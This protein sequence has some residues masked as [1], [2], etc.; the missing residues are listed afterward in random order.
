MANAHTETPVTASIL[1]VFQ[2]VKSG[3][4][5]KDGILAYSIV[6][7]GAGAIQVRES[8]H[9]DF[10]ADEWIKLASGRSITFEVQADELNRNTQILRI[11]ARRFGSVSSTISGG[12]VK[13]R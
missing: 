7:D 11:Q 4:V 2:S 6:N 8:G 3:G 12:S 13:R 1:E 10:D 5:D 9:Q